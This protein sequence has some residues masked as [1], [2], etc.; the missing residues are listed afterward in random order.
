MDSISP[1]SDLNILECCGF[2]APSEEFTVSDPSHFESIFTTLLTALRED[3]IPLV[4]SCLP[5]IFMLAVLHQIPGPWQTSSTL[6]LSHQLLKHIYSFH[7]AV[8]MLS[9]LTTPTR[10]SCLLS[11]LL[12]PIQQL[13]ASDGWDSSP[14][15]KLIATWLQTQLP[16]PT[17]GAHLHLF[18]PILLRLLD[19]LSIDNQVLGLTSTLHMTRNVTRTDLLVYD[20]AGVLVNALERYLYSNYHQVLSNYQPVIL[21]LLSV[22]EEAPC[23]VLSPHS[24]GLTQHDTFLSDLLSIIPLSYTAD[25]KRDRVRLLVETVPLFQTALQPHL[26][27]LV[28]CLVFCLEMPDVT[29]E[30]TRLLSMDLVLFICQHCSQLMHIYLSDLSLALIKVVT[31]CS[32]G[33][34]DNKAKSTTHQQLALKSVTCFHK[35]HACESC[36][37]ILDYLHAVCDEEQGSIF[38]ANMLRKAITRISLDKS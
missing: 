28:K 16:Y 2:T 12:S 24:L 19:D 33:K 38:V 26:S 31:Q 18:F 15:G 10:D 11:D 9:L 34:Q 29:Q 6:S 23:R 36:G 1:F 37:D 3:D 5:P 35:L 22:I 27:Q 13:I 7:R 32:K 17:L 8:D 25:L 14:T 4:P 30:E 21:Q 20:R